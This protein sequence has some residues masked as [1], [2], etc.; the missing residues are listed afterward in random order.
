M[1]I[2]MTGLLAFPFVVTVWAI[3]AYLFL[4]VVHLI[5]RP[6]AAPPNVPAWQRSLR[7]LVDPLPDTVRAWRTKVRGE[8]PN[9][10][11]WTIVIGSL[12]LVRQICFGTAVALSR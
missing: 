3:D 4:V 5:A 2:D 11:V 6:A 7:T 10:A 12:F 9:W 8:L 1:I